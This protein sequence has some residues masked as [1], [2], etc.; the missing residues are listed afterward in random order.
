MAFKLRALATACAFL[1]LSALFQGPAM[2]RQGDDN[3][4]PPGIPRTRAA[5]ADDHRPAMRGERRAER[6]Q[7]RRDEWRSDRREWRNDRREWR[8]DHTEW[9]SNRREWRDDHR[10]GPRVGVVV[11]VLPTPY[12]EI[13]HQRRSYFYANGYWYDPWGSSFIRIAAPIGVVISSLP[14]GYATVSLGGNLYYR[15][16]DTWYRPHDSGYVVVPPPP[17]AD[18]ADASDDTLFA[19]PREN[20]DER[21]QADDRFQCHEWAARQS[22]YD[23][24]LSSAGGAREDELQQ[25]PAYLRAMTACLEGRGYT[26]R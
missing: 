2:A 26:V 13:R 15:Y 21:Q 25:R 14:L 16:D 20:Q 8:N 4:N 17:E 6:R 18:R 11:P 22:G 24:S 3:D 7:D 19:Y 12:R 9:R 10:H 1:A 23:P 5:P